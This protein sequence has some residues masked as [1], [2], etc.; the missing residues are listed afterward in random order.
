MTGMGPKS[1]SELLGL[2]FVH[3]VGK[4][5]GNQAGGA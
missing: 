3:T 4:E 1:E 5:I 2:K